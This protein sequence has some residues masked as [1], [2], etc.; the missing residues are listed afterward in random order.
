MRSFPRTARRRLAAV[1]AAAALAAGLLCAPAAPAASPDDD[2]KDKQDR[3]EKRIDRA[4]S[5]FEH[6]SNRATRAAA[7]LQGARAR[8]RAAQGRLT[9][10][11]GRLV[12]ARE[13]DREMREQLALAIARLQ[14]ARRVLADARGRIADQRDAVSDVVSEVY[15][16]GDPEL[17]AFASLLDAQ[18]P[19]DLTR[20]V[21]AQR[22]I[23]GQETRAYDS[24]RA[25][26]VLLGVQEDEVEEALD[27]ARAAPSPNWDGVAASVLEENDRMQRLVDDLLVIARV[28]GGVERRDSWTLVD[29]DDVVLDEAKRLPATTRIDLSEVSAGQ[30]RGDTEQLRRVVRNLLD[31]ALRHAESAVAVEVR[32]SDGLVEMS[33]DDDGPGIAPDDRERVFERFVRLDD[34]RSRRDGGFGLGLPIVLDLARRHD[35]AVGVSTSERLG[36]A[37]VTVTL[38]DARRSERPVDGAPSQPGAARTSSMNVRP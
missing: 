30:V 20:R 18:D 25:T 32:S 4:S 3:V 38:P 15:R 34:A 23:V 16:E 33:V 35:G 28:D 13:R 14:E 8:L 1:S 11:Q 22:V 21:E 12:A 31:N 24:L 17:I 29:L 37:R 19:A 6:S 9:Q 36:G 26:E 27:V 7:A 5:E 2:L 10:A